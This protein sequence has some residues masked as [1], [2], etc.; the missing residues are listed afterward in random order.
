VT[1]TEALEHWI[2]DAERM[3]GGPAHGV[4]VTDE[5]LAGLR[6]EQGARTPIVAGMVVRLSA[7][8]GDAA[9]TFSEMVEIAGPDRVAIYVGAPAEGAEFPIGL[10]PAMPVVFVP[11]EPG[12]VTTTEQLEMYNRLRWYG[13]GP[14]EALAGAG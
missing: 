8:S 10:D 9:P 6:A 4:V 13:V 2:R 11:V 7:A 14:D 3:S 5:L 12:P 1:L